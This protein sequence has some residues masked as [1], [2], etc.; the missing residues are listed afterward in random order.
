M[1]RDQYGISM[2]PE[3][4]AQKICYDIAYDDAV[5]VDVPVFLEK[6]VEGL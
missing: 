5:W 1:V 6:T 2:Q 3:D 4:C